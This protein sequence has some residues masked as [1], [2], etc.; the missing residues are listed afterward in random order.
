STAGVALIDPPFGLVDFVEVAWWHPLQPTDMGLTW[1]RG[2]VTEVAAALRS[3]AGPARAA[4]GRG[5]DLAAA[6]RFGVT[7]NR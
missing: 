5:G 2:I 7:L 6:A 3:R 1:L 4:P